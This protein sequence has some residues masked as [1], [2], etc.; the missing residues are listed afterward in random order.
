M[1][2]K[3]DL[4]KVAIFSQHSTNSKSFRQDYPISSELRQIIVGEV[5]NDFMRYA[6]NHYYE[7]YLPITKVFLDEHEINPDKRSSLE[8]N[9][10][11]WRLMYDLDLNISNCVEG[12]IS[13]NFNRLC[14]RPFFISWL[15]EFSKAQP[16][17][18]E[19]IE[20]HYNRFFIVRDILE[21]QAI[22]VMVYDP[23]AVPPKLGEIVIGTLLPIGGGIFFPVN[24]FYHFDFEVRKVIEKNLP[25][26]YDKLLKKSNEHEAFIHVLSAML[27]MESIKHLKSTV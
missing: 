20:I 1:E 7:Q 16:K 12:F 26:Y 27:Q 19:V 25:I 22:E 11:W 24:D 8:I 13:G 15:R 4:E 21:N 10:F 5:F 18:Y 14:K 9:M 23:I 2:E 6:M 3:K 17:F